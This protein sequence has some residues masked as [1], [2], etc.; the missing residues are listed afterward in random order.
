MNS[1]QTH[2]KTTKMNCT[3]C[4]VAIIVGIALM[5]SVEGTGG[6]CWKSTPD[7]EAMKLAPCA[8]AAKDENAAV[9][10]SCCYQ[11]KVIGHN[12]SCLCAVF[13]SDTAKNSGYDPKIAL[14]IPKRCNFAHRPIGYKCGP[15]TLP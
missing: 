8:S 3:M 11:V 5:G 1:T 12:P 13:L 10:E 7:N 2:S 14:T 15:Y 4:L 9:P 6:P